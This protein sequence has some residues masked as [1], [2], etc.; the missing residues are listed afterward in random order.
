MGAPPGPRGRLSHDITRGTSVPAPILCR[1]A[2]SRANRSAS[3]FFQTPSFRTS[4]TGDVEWDLLK[5]KGTGV[6]ARASGWAVSLRAD[7]P[8]E[9]EGPSEL[10]LAL[11]PSK[12]PMRN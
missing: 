12:G 9:A 11:N 8:A 10:A 5:M 1:P 6:S 4:W 3:T 7:E 2:L